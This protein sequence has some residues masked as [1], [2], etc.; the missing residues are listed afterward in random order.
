[1]TGTQK[2]IA[3]QHSIAPECVVTRHGSLTEDQFR[4]LLSGKIV[5]DFNRRVKSNRKLSLT[6]EPQWLG[7]Y[8]DQPG[9]K[10]QARLLSSGF[11]KGWRKE[12][13]PSPTNLLASALC[14]SIAGML[15]GKHPKDHRLRVT[16][17]RSI[18][19]HGEEL[20]QQACDYQGLSL[21]D[22]GAARRTF[23]A[24]NATIGLAYLCRRIVRSKKRVTAGS[25]RT[26]MKGLRLDRASSDMRKDVGFVLAIPLVEAGEFYTSPSPV[27]GVI[28][29]DS[30]APNY[31]IDDH[32]LTVLVSIA[33]TFLDDMVE[34]D[35][36]KLGGIRNF[37][38][39]ELSKRRK[40]ASELPQAARKTL[41][42]ANL[43]P[44]S[45]QLPYQINYDFSDFAP[46]KTTA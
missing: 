38:L 6:D 10:R 2:D 16:L 22:D 7:G 26:T 9:S 34:R 5:Q 30:N 14:A 37:P 20:L 8:F 39:A 23:P 36:E 31:Y 43:L 25:L 40:K 35:L 17:H 15:V 11:K 12:Y 33:Q 29:I 18:V 3:A 19:I 24:R 42:L 4:R 13:L 21:D 28:F 1:M 32:D 46:T 44:P 45:T 27:A 41:E